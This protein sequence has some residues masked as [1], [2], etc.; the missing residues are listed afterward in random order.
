MKN[1]RKICSK[2]QIE[3]SLTEFHRSNQTKDGYKYY[4]KICR[5][6]NGKKYREANKEKVQFRHKIYRENNKEKE[7]LRH[8]NIKKSI[9]K[10]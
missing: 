2:C 10:K 6:I 9:K 1:S 4:C 8:K 7:R 3:K 5:A